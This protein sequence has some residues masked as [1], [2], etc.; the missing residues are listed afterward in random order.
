MPNV[1]ECMEPLERY[2]MVPGTV[3]CVNESIVS[4]RCRA[5][6]IVD[7]T[8]TDNIHCATEALVNLKAVNVPTATMAALAQNGASLSG[9]RAREYLDKDSSEYL[10]LSASTEPLPEAS[11]ITVHDRDWKKTKWKC[12]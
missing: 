2:K 11:S 1:N 3:T 12:P 5:T 10:S 9:S 8:V 4:N 7:V 6:V